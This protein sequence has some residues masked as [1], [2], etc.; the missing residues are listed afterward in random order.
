M[1]VQAV[2]ISTVNS[3][4]KRCSASKKQVICF[5]E[6]LVN[7]RQTTRCRSLEEQEYITPFFGNIPLWFCK[8]LVLMPVQTQYYFCKADGI[9]SGI[10][11]SKNLFLFYRKPSPTADSNHA[12]FSF[13]IRFS[14]GSNL[15]SYIQ[16]FPFVY[17][18]KESVASLTRGVMADDLNWE[19]E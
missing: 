18:R 6:T 7:T 5:L 11:Q 10:V 3:H 8:P 17:T 1:K 9:I 2:V 16:S 14:E 13:R 4:N 12:R 19:S 15:I